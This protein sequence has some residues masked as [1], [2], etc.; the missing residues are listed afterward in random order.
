MKILVVD[1][2]PLI[3]QYIVQCIRAADPLVEIVDA[4][5]SGTKALKKLEDAPIDLVLTDITM[6]KMDGIELLRIIKT[7]Y[8]ATDVIMLTCHDDFAYAR[9]A[10]QNQAS[11]YILKNEVNPALF[12]EVFDNLRI[13]HKEQ[14]TK[15][16]TSH[17][18]RNKYLRDLIEQDVAKQ[19]VCESDLRENHIYL[20][21]CTFVVFLFH[22]CADNMQFVQGNL[23]DGFENQL[24]YDYENEDMLLLLNLSAKAAEQIMEIFRTMESQLRGVTGLSMVHQHLESLPRAIREAFQD[25]DRRFYQCSEQMQGTDTNAAQLEPYIMR[26]IIKMEDEA[27]EEGCIEIEKLLAFSQRQYPSVSLLKSLMIQ[28]LIGIRKKRGLSVERL[29]EQI[30]DSKTFSEFCVCVQNALEQ[31]RQ[32]NKRYS[33]PI[34]KALEYI[35]IHYAEDI[36]LNLV[37][38]FVYLNRDYLSRQFKKEVGVNFSEYLTGLRMKQAKHL[39]E[40]TNM[41]ISDVALSIGMSNMSYF[42]TVFHRS[43]GCTPN[44]ARKRNRT[45][46]MS[47]I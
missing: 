11:N 20:E 26:A 13:S 5:T 39:L 45:D 18:S 15:R 41:R 36:S 12:R 28:V 4:V 29:E 22:N 37:A 3:G 34:R 33:E 42:S 24:F 30:L 21:D 10:I 47:K 40:T 44:E 43:F 31:L 2:E 25:R 16:A 38:D 27:V 17:I 6:P 1:D 7:R 23:P 46:T 14:N 35:G 8:P 9:A 19:S 32:S